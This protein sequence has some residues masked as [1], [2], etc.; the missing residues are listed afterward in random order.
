MMEQKN[1]LVYTHDS[2]GLG[3]DGP[4]HQ[5]VEHIN[6][7]RMMPLLDVW[8][9]CDITETVVAWISALEYHGTT[10]LVL[11]R[12]KLPN[13]NRSVEQIRN[14]QRGGYILLDND[15][16]E[17][18]LVATGSE[19]SIA[20]DAAKQLSDRMAVRVVS[21]PCIEKFKEQPKEYQENIL[22]SSIQKRIAIEAGSSSIWYEFIGSNGTIIGLDSFGKSAPFTDIYRHFNLTV[23]SV[24]E[25]ALN[26]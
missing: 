4:T 25:K 14:I 9:P 22:P 6:S 7:L 1:I 10:A 2:I 5:P 20:I 21:M 16:P 18:I 12:Q 3:E 19:V 13:Q 26:L 8:R 24:I 23:E 15:N 17:I 11:S